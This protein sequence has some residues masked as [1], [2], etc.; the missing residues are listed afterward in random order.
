MG[1]ARLFFSRSGRAI[2]ATLVAKGEKPMAK[3]PTKKSRGFDLD[4]LRLALPAEARTTLPTMGASVAVFEAKRLYLHA[5]P[6]RAQFAKLPGFRLSDLDHLPHMA[7]ALELAEKR[8]TVAR[9]DKQAPSLKPLRKEAETLKAAMFAAARYLFRRD[10][11]VQTE[12]DRIAEGDDLADLLQDLRDLVALAQA[13]AAVW[14]GA[15]TLPKRHLVRAIE[16]ADQLTNGVDTTPALGAQGRRN[17]AFWILQSAVDEVRSA[18]MYLLH[19]Q[20]KRL[21]PMLSSHQGETRRA[22]RRTRGSSRAA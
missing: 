15:I 14:A 21:A 3:R 12:L 9:M 17:Q 19:D 5:K 2:L 1:P 4:V 13:N 6:L 22:V 7:A 18:A 10:A 16:L 20:P 11:A 8:W